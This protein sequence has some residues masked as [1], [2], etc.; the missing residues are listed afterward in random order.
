MN[1]VCLKHRYSGAVECPQCAETVCENCHVAPST[2]NWGGTHDQVSLARNPQL[3]QRWC[4]R[5]VLVARIAYMRGLVP[6][7]PKLEA[8]LATLD[9]LTK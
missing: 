5:C 1:Q 7:L 9:K 4:H 2:E 8:E 3:V 6:Q